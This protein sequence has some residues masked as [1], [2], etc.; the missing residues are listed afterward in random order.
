MIDTNT[1]NA[2]VGKR[3]QDLRKSKGMTG[4]DL[5]EKLGLAQSYVS[6]LENGRRSWKVEMLADIANILDVRMVD[7]FV[8]EDESTRL[9]KIENLLEQ[10]RE[11]EKKYNRLVKDAEERAKKISETSLNP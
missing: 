9:A 2:L 3:V 11:M 7:F 1:I 6:N 4:T 10:V 8:E 5:A